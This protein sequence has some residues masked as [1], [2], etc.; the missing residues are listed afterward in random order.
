MAAMYAEHVVGSY[1]VRD[2]ALPV[3]E[4][5]HIH[6]ELENTTCIGREMVEPHLDNQSSLVQAPRISF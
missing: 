1:H 3:L 2:A 5:R 4:D 6:R